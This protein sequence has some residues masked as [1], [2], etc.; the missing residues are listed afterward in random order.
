M[1]AAALL[2]AL[3]LAGCLGV[4]VP[5]TDAPEAQTASSDVLPWAM[6]HCRYVVAMAQAD[7]QKLQSRMP[8]GFRAA[9]RGVLPGG[10]PVTSAYLGVEAFECESG[11]GLNETPVQGLVYGSLFAL[12]VPPEQVLDENVTLYMAKWDVLVPDPERR[13]RLLEAGL[14]VMDGKVEW[15]GGPAGVGEGAR[16]TLGE[17]GTFVFALGPGQR[18]TSQGTASFYEFTPS[19]KGGYATWRADY[20]WDSGSF[21]T[22]RGA[23]TLPAGWAADAVGGTRVPMSY[24]AGTWTFSNGTLA[25]PRAG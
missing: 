11:T 9:T 3:A 21:T 6:A 1:R 12:V 24:H 17:V 23:L 14:P 5:T 19:E 20:A 10:L 13:A 4:D 18:A 2:L 16:L 8:E 15:A 22:G 25:L 7:A